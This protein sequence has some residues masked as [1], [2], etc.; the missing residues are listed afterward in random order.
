VCFGKGIESQAR[1]QISLKTVYRAGVKRLELFTESGDFLVSLDGREP[2]MWMLF[3]HTLFAGSADEHTLVFERDGQRYPTI[4]LNRTWWMARN[5]NYDFGEFSVFYENDPRNGE[6][7]GRLY[8]PWLTDTIVCPPG[9]RLPR[10]HEWAALE[11]YLGMSPDQVQGF[12]WRGNDQAR[13]MLAGGTSGLEILPA[14][15]KEYNGGFVY[16]EERALFYS[17]YNNARIL[18]LGFG[19]IYR[20]DGGFE[21]FADYASVRC[22]RRY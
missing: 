2:G 22:I 1:L 21:P 19:K 20:A 17:R 7:Y 8:S 9:W 18:L 12:L 3:Q 5:L 13:Q 10:E 11:A 4:R 14:G 16:K 6:K 15:Y